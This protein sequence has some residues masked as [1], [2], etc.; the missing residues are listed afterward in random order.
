MVFIAGIMVFLE[1]MIPPY[2]SW[3]IL[4][5]S[6]T[7]WFMA[8]I[9]HVSGR[10]KEEKLGFSFKH[11][12]NCIL[13]IEEKKKKKK[14]KNQ[15]SL[16]LYECIYFHLSLNWKIRRIFT[17]FGSPFVAFEFG[18]YSD[19][20]IWDMLST[21]ACK[22]IYFKQKNKREFQSSAIV[23]AGKARISA[24]AFWIS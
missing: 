10:T 8:A 2:N 21:A 16:I 18:I 19:P 7:I 17:F 9:Q 11:S 24:F 4:S 14:K 15:N 22:G 5:Y 12:V 23:C 13:T 6:P 3:A 1:S 20:S